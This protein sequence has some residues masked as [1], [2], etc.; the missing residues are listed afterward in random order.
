MGDARDAGEI[1]PRT[2]PFRRVGAPLLRFFG[3]RDMG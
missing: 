3:R 2:R 1:R